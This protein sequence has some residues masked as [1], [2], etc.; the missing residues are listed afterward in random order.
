MRVTFGTLDDEAVSLYSVFSSSKRTLS[1]VEI[2]LRYYVVEFLSNHF[3]RIGGIC[4]V[5]LH[6]VHLAP[7]I[8]DFAIFDACGLHA[9]SEVSL[10][11]G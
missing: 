11:F 8:N 1:G 2:E 7:F 9:M 6:I 3:N 5:G 10:K 4:R